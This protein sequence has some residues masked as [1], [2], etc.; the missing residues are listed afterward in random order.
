MVRRFSKNSF[1]T[2][3]EEF[4][5]RYSK[6]S[7][8]S[9]QKMTLPL[10]TLQ[11]EFLKILAKCPAPSGLCHRL[12]E[13]KLNLTLSLSTRVYKW[14]PAGIPLGVTLQW[15][16]VPLRGSSNTLCCFTLQPNRVKLRPCGC[17]VACVKSS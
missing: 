7:G 1:Q 11:L 14:V 4:V 10:N 3:K 2:E 8:W 13:K 9:F 16:I 5:R 17:P 12:V 6:I 15:T